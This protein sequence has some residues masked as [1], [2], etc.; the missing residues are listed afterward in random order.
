MRSREDSARA[1]ARYRLTWRIGHWHHVVK[2]GCN[3]RCGR[4]HRG[5]RLRQLA[6]IKPKIA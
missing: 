4:H 2:S 6:A 5:E 1:S 3:V